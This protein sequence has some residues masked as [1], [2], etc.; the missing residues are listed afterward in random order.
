MWGNIVSAF[1]NTLYS[2]N[3]IPPAK[4]KN[5]PVLIITFKG[6]ESGFLNPITKV[7]T[8]IPITSSMIAALTI[9]VPTVPFNLPISLRDWTVML[10]LVAV[11]I[12]PINT[13]L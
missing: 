12:T 13:A 7:S 3:P 2:K 5:N 4:M 10:T 9:V 8:T 1:E 11:I 6:F